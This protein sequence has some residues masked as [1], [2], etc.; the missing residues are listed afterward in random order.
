MC[1]LKVIFDLPT[2][3]EKNGYSKATNAVISS[4]KINNLG[5]T[6]KID[7]NTGLGRTI[8]ILKDIR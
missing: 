2:D 5:W 6:A 8:K 3:Q 7:I 4:E 1:E